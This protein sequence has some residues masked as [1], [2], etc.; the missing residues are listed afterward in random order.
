MTSA[1][2]ERT[3]KSA[4]VAHAT[5]LDL[6][7]VYNGTT[8]DSSTAIG[9]GDQVML[10]LIR[11][12]GAKLDLLIPKSAK[13]LVAS[14]GRLFLTLGNLPLNLIGV[15]T[16]FFVRILQGIFLS[17]K[18][19]HVYDIAV[20]VS[21]YSVDL[22]P[23]WFWK[24]RRKGAIIYHII[25]KRKA[26][27]WST[28]I[29]FAL[30]AVEQR[31]NMKLLART[32]DF[33][34]AGNNFTKAQLESALPGK[35]IFV[36]DAGFDAS[37]IDRVPSP[38]KNLNL[39]C[40][41]GRLTSQKGIF[42]LVKVMAALRKTNPAFRLIMVGSGPEREFLLAE[43][44]RLGLDNITLAGFISDEEK[45]RLLKQS[46]FFFF[47][48]Y[49]E[50]WGIALA[51]ALYCECRCICYELTHYRSIF[52][53]F[54]TYAKLGDPDDFLRKFQ[55]IQSH[56]VAP[57]QKNY[58]RQYDDPIIVR[59]FTDHLERLSRGTP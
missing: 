13:T 32:C 4:P 31:I 26:V 12:S 8:A 41:V 47:P 2:P 15:M 54:P 50:G 21:P 20:S 46:A 33:L 51:E 37:A 25:P 14:P 53:D 29:R 58:L 38:P 19:K 6:F 28:R 56:A 44:K 52:Q 1:S 9:G 10:K 35:T 59:R 27:N 36:L 11:L 34:V 7:L 45:I 55:A 3:S 49:E 17:F 48:S 22:I 30:A 5:S 42:D 39:A 40:F 18:N 43:M 23:L 16:L 57:D 24:A